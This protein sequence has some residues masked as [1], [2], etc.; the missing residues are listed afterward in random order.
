M[1][2]ITGKAKDG[3]DVDLTIYGPDETVAHKR[4]EFLFRPCI[5]K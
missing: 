1:N 4:I 3:S 2:C 5:P